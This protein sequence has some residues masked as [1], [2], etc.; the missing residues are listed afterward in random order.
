MFVVVQM[1]LSPVC[2]EGIDTDRCVIKSDR[3]HKRSK[4]SSK[5]DALRY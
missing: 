1:E 5:L 4:V 2:T 3:G